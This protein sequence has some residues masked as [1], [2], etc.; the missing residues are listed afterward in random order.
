MEPTSMRVRTIPVHNKVKKKAR[1][2]AAGAPC[3]IAENGPARNA[4]DSPTQKSKKVR[5]TD[6]S[7][8]DATGLDLSVNSSREAA[9]LGAYKLKVEMAKNAERTVVVDPRLQSPQKKYVTS[10]SG[11]QQVELMKKTHSPIRLHNRQQNHPH[12]KHHPN[13]YDRLSS[14]EAFTINYANRVHGTHL[15]GHSGDYFDNPLKVSKMLMN[16]SYSDLTIPGRAQDF[17]SSVEW[18]TQLRSNLN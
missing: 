14:E 11:V 16:S 6:R 3:G 8:L 15:D 18:R 4:S 12:K 10:V 13:L 7:Y 17:S 5:K 9:L 1:M 2:E